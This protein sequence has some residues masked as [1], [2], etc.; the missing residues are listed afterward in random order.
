MKPRIRQFLIA[1]CVVCLLCVSISAA[2]VFRDGLYYGMAMGRNGW[3][4]VSVKVDGGVIADI[5]VDGPQETP[6]KLGQAMQIVGKLR[7]LSDLESV[8]AVDAISGAT[9]SSNGIKNAVINALQAA[10]LTWQHGAGEDCPSAA[11]TDLPAYGNWAHEPIDWAVVTGVTQGVSQTAFAPE[12][13][14]T[15]AQI[16]TFLWRAAGCPEVGSLDDSTMVFTDVSEDDYYYSAVL[17]AA[18]RGITTGIT[19]T[20]FGPNE[21]CTRAQAVTFLWRAAGCPEGGS[22]DVRFTDVSE[23]DYYFGAVRWAVGHGVTQGVS[24]TAF[25]PQSACTRAQ[26]VTLLFRAR[27]AY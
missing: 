13:T 24:Q 1:V 3:I 5:A 25:A 27:S 2:S 26:I 19:A 16:V 23:G 4:S 7:G 11:F 14:C 9:D 22:L 10:V 6:A 12:S 15:R 21:R 17:W 20:R 18:E 8:Q